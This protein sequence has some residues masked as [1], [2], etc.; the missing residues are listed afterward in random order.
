MLRFLRSLILRPT[1]TT[2]STTYRPTHSA[3]CNN[4]NHRLDQTHLVHE[5]A[6]EEVTH[7]DASAVTSITVPLRD[8]PLWTPSRLPFHRLAQMTLLHVRPYRV[9]YSNHPPTD[10]LLHFC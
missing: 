5:V 10:P 7:R 3:T 9:T 8:P 4:P 2:F 6:V 1:S